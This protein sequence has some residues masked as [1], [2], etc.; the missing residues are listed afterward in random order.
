MKFKPPSKS[1]K[2]NFPL[3]T[4]AAIQPR[5][6]KNVSR[7]VSS[8]SRDEDLFTRKE[9]HITAGTRRPVKSMRTTM[10]EDGERR[11]LKKML[12]ESEERYRA[13]METASEA[14]MVHQNGKI[15]YS[16]PA[17]MELIGAK[18]SVE[19]LEKNYLDVVHHSGNNRT[20]LDEPPPDQLLSHEVRIIRLNGQCIDAE[21]LEA[22]ISFAGASATQ[23]IIQ[24]VTA[25]KM[26]EQAM[27]FQASVLSEVH[28][29]VVV[30][31]NE[32]RITYYN[33][34]AELLYEST[35]AD[36]LG[37]KL[38]EVNPYGWIPQGNATEANESLSRR[39]FWRGSGLH[40]SVSGI[41]KFVE[42]SISVLKDERGA[43]IGLLAVM[44]DI[45]ER[46]QADNALRES[47]ER[48]RSLVENS[49]VAICVQQAGRYVYMNQAG[50]QLFGA[51]EPVQ[52]I[53][54]E[55]I[56]YVHPDYRDSIIEWMRQI[57]E[58]DRHLPFHELKILR[59]NGQAADVE[60]VV[61]KTSFGGQPATQ[62]LLKDISEIR[63]TEL[64]LRLQ[65]T[66]LSQVKDAVVAVDSDGRIIFWNRAAELLFKVS[67][68][69]AIGQ[70]RQMI[71]GYRPEVQNE[72]GRNFSAQSGFLRGENIHIL[73]NGDEIQVESSV[74]VLT[75]WSG[76]PAGWLAVMRDIT[77]RKRAEREIK[78]AR[79]EA[80]RERLRM[81]TIVNTIPSGVFV[82]EGPDASITLQN[83]QARNILGREVNPRV[84]AGERIGQYRMRRPDGTYF[85]SDEI[86]YLHAFHTGEDVRDVEIMLERPDGATITILSQSVPLRDATGAVYGSVSAFNDITE[87][88]QAENE[89]RKARA[90]LEL[91]VRERTAELSTTLEAL[92][93]EFIVRRR[94]EKSLEE[95][96][97]LLENIF[98]TIHV[99]I[100]YMDTGFDYIRV[101]QN[102]AIREGHEPEFYPGRNYFADIQDD[103]E[104]EIFR[105]VVETGTPYFAYGK[106]LPAQK[107][108]GSD[109]TYWDW[110]VVPVKESDGRVTGLVLSAIDVTER[111]RA[112]MERARLVAAIE[113]AAEAVVITET[114]RGTI[115]Y[116]NPAFELITGYK[117]EEA[118]GKTLHILESGKHDEEFY[119]AMRAAIVRDGFWK[120][121]LINKKKDGTHYYEE[122]TYSPVRDESGNIVSYVS[123]KHD[124][125]EK[126][127]LESI[128]E[129]VDTMNTIGY[130]FSGIRH[131]IGNPISSLLIIL[132]LMKK[133]F[134]A[135]PK[136]V[137]V[138]YLEQ[139][140]AQVERVEYLLTTLKNFNMYENLKIANVQVSG[141]MEKFITLIMEDMIRKGIQL[142]VSTI[143]NTGCMSADPRAL[144]QALL[145]IAVNAADAV[146]G[147]PDPKITLHTGKA[148]GM[149]RIRISDNGSGI[150]EAG[151]K[152]LFK[153]FY[154]SKA[155]G[156]GLGLVITKKLVSRMNGL[157]EIT[158][159][160]DEGTTVDIYIPGGT[161]EH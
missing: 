41:A 54:K 121:R 109:V 15:V 110:N 64:R 128:A 74:S 33:K 119:C 95:T 3:Q 11:R 159:R 86:P 84:G 61:T 76:A 99:A 113:A 112:E 50:L 16:N 89:L 103:Q 156:T 123:I 29:A 140:I 96:S 148:R 81:E 122:C 127:R 147:K 138:G 45:T 115:Q 124:V 139:A 65:A 21:A 31:D 51:E 19:L 6:G 133:K 154:T 59:V 2:P 18:H 120:G 37:K 62:A 136:E 55:A 24:D 42:S 104:Q 158:S 87:R 118:V 34:G 135:G 40:R 39:G 129:T 47:E 101:N 102:Y 83:E 114:N 153:P 145:N 36:A 93:A 151:Q 132:G 75:G 8:T 157:I 142:E 131:E 90:E 14:I 72:A 56:E 160:I 111:K 94:A 143:P 91:R 134:E 149:V 108:P 26:A 63:N 71:F 32:S 97:R 88:K 68:E 1:K 126:L 43:R 48:Y 80:L 22:P 116:V 20:G 60:A 10:N 144:Q 141:F 85:K 28:D 106:P 77:E 12:S 100:A 27:R 107:I 98:A 49:P 105:R 130:A 117:R 137:L 38:Q 69:E 82:A 152:D 146:A 70:H 13:L 9:N 66:V 73:R 58:N 53:G 67:A 25:R 46:R 4:K 78:E 7:D 57:E 35:A 52:I 150:P 155:H 30:I 5:A 161:I 17:G 79:D 23:V 125:T 44:R 92:Q